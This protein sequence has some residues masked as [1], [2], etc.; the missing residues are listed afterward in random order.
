MGKKRIR[1]REQLIKA[2]A[3]FHLKQARLPYLKKMKMVDMLMDNPWK[4]K[5]AGR[6]HHH[7]IDSENR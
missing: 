7:L 1:T 6:P 4:G 3:E 2:Q 5:P